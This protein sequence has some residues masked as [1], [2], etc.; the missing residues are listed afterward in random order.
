MLWNE[1]V[2]SSFALEVIDFSIDILLW[3]FFNIVK[4]FVMVLLNSKQNVM[5]VR[6][7]IKSAIF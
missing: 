4:F 1:S 2:C 3:Y 6:Y 7:S 5:L